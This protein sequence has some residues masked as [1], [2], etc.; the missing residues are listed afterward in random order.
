MSTAWTPDQV[1]RIEDDGRST[2]PFDPEE[3]E[4]AL[5]HLYL[6]DPW[7]VRGP[8]TTVATLA[9]REI[10]MALS[11]PSTL[12]PGERHDVARIRLI[13]LGDGGWAD[14]GDLF[15]EGGSAGSR[16]W[17][18]CATLRPGGELE[19]RYTAA[20]RR[21]SPPTFE[22]RI[23]RAVGTLSADLTP[24]RWG[25][26]EVAVEAG[27]PY[28]DTG[29]QVSGEPGFI[30]AFRDP[31]VFVDPGDGSPYMLFTASLSDANSQFNGAIG[32]VRAGERLDPLITADGVNNELERP[33]VVA[34]EGSYYLFFSTQERTFHPDVPGPTGLYGFVG[35]SM[36]GP[37]EPLN[38]SGLVLRNPPEEPFQAYSWLVL[39]DLRVI[40]F[41]D[42]HHLRGRSPGEVEGSGSGREHFGGTFAPQE[43]IRLE[44]ARSQ[45]LPR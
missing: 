17:A 25:E 37:W 33:H 12:Q 2:K 38:H 13:S 27:G 3:C 29:D 22:Q 10:W 24:G 26:H 30:K 14:H 16:E 44:G 41:I 15:A 11:A 39:D 8:G 45:L 28:V 4:R 18:G 1:G 42:F 36:G 6:W 35:P 20:G 34:Y 9:G 43:Q 7:P 31:F 23:M 5:P 19:V 32:V 21:G 40:S